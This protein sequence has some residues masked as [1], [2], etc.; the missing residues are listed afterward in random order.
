MRYQVRI[1][2]DTALPEGVEWAFARQAG[3]TYLFVKKSAVAASPGTCDAL[4]RAWT[5]WQQVEGAGPQ[6]EPRGARKAGGLR[7]LS[8]ALLATWGP[9]LTGF[10]AVVL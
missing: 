6:G 9:D 4:A 2:D 8:A 1:V 10:D 7:A 3:H 5:C